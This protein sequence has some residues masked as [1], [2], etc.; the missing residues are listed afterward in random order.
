MTNLDRLEAA[1]VG[2]IV[3]LLVM[4]LAAQVHHAA[5]PDRLERVTCQEDEPCWDCNAMGNHVCGPFAR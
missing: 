1:V 2:A 4:V 3:A 5:Q